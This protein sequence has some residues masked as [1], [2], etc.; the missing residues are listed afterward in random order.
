M[1]FNASPITSTAAADLR[2]PERDARAERQAVAS[3][4][5]I[6]GATLMKPVAEAMGPMGAFFGD[7]LARAA[8]QRAAS[9]DPA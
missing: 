4:E 3:F 6:L 8:L 5:A 9:D 7:A 1:R 2:A